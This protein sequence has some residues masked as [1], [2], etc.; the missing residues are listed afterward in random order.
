M[1]VMCT[2]QEDKRTTLQQRRDS[3][4]WSQEAQTHKGSWRET[5]VER[6]EEMR[7]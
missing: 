7:I 2:C 3:I 6:M 4:M 5:C 1:E